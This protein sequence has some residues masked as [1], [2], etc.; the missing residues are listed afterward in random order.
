MY[1]KTYGLFFGL[2]QWD[3]LF[4][5]K[6]EGRKYKQVKTQDGYIEQRDICIYLYL[7]VCVMTCDLN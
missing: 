2:N 1:F 7:I 4:P 3:S 5:S 6:V